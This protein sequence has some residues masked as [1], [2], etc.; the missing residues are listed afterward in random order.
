[1]LELFNLSNV[2]GE[3]V[4]VTKNTPQLWLVLALKVNTGISPVL[5]LQYLADGGIMLFVIYF[6]LVLS[7][8][9]HNIT[10]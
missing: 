5:F 1:M 10:F 3:S 9:Q 6:C 7:N 4:Q 2:V 8:Q